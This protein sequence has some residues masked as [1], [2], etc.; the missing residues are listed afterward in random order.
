MKPPTPLLLF[1][2]SPPVRHHAP[3]P[4]SPVDPAPTSTLVSLPGPA[5]S[6]SPLASWP[7]DL[8]ALGHDAASSG[9]LDLGAPIQ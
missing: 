3:I 5:T 8:A 7:A 9:R 1:P 2:P 4:P 6:P